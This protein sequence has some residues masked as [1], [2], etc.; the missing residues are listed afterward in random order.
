MKFLENKYK[1]YS[2]KWFI[3]R[4][5]IVVKKSRLPQFAIFSGRKKKK[6]RPVPESKLISPITRLEVK[7]SE[8]Q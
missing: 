5:I 6:I 1:P 4:T 8:P 7:I 2:I 3:Q